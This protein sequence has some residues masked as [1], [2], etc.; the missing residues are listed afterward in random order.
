[1]KRGLVKIDRGFVIVAA[2]ASSVAAAAAGDAA[3]P[4]PVAVVELFTS[5]GCARC[6]PADAFLTELSADR[7]LVTITWAVDYWDWLGWKDTA[8]KPEFTRRQKSYAAARGDHDVFTPQLVVDGR[9]HLVGS[10]RAAVRRELIARAGHPELSVAVELETTGDAL[11]VSIGDAAAGTEPTS[12]TVWLVRYHLARSVP[13]GRGENTGRTLTYA[14][15][16]RSLQPIG[17]WKGR[18]LRIE[19]PKVDAAGEQESG[20]AVLVQGD[21]GGLPGPIVGARACPTPAG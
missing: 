19:V 10:D 9:R 8:A 5:Q 20:C 1:M 2:L 11:V 18:A 15:L 4:R 13:V 6:P 16:A 14:H 21:R 7:D 12:A 3:S 17:M